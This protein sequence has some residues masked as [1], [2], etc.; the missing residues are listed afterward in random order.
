M[1]KK[2]LYYVN[3]CILTSNTI[4]FYKYFA[5]Q[6]NSGIY[7]SPIVAFLGFFIT[8]YLSKTQC[9]SRTEVFIQNIILTISLLT[10]AIPIGLLILIGANVTA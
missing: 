6:G 4:L 1:N 3:L 7:L 5:P 9:L 10:A 8:L 2:I